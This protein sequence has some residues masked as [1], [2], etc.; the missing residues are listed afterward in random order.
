MMALAPLGMVFLTRLGPDTAQIRRMY[1]RPAHRR[2]GV[3]NA[4][5]GQVLDLAREIGYARL[6]LESPRSWT[7]AHAVYT[8]HGFGPVD[9]H[10]ESE[11]P[12]SLQQY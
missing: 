2:R 1:V 4:L 7:G 8:A 3:G 10:P 12:K 5:F 9:A 6:L 11:V